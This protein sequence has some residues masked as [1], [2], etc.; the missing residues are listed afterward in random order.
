MG[1]LRPLF[2]RHLNGSETSAALY[3]FQTLLTVPVLSQK[4]SFTLQSCYI[5]CAL[6]G[7]Q[8]STGS[9]SCLVILWLAT[10]MSRWKADGLGSLPCSTCF[11][12]LG[13]TCRIFTHP[14]HDHILQLINAILTLIGTFGGRAQN[15]F[16]RGRCSQRETFTLN[17]VLQQCHLTHGARIKRHDGV[18]DKLCLKFHK[19]S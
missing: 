5:I 16:C 17:H 9:F 12:G 18:V 6:L 3:I 4:H 14:E 7:G 10:F 8:R 2:E 19:D 15:V 1:E 13:S 11:Q